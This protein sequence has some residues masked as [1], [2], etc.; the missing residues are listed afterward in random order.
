VQRQR[1]PPTGTDHQRLLHGHL[2]SLHLLAQRR[3]RAAD[4]LSG[5]THRAGLRD[6]HEIPEQVDVELGRHAINLPY[7]LPLIHNVRERAH[8]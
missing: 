3:L 1:D 5:A 2:E 6:G 4:A 8:C 7:C